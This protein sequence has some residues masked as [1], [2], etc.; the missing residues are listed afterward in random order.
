MSAM[1]A[2]KANASAV[3]RDYSVEPRTRYS[4]ISGVS[5]PVKYAIV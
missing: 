2:F 5:M 1:D 4:T 3:V